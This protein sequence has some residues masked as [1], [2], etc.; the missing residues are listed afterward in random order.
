MSNC[1][2]FY[3]NDDNIGLLDPILLTT[4][5]E[6]NSINNNNNSSFHDNNVMNFAIVQPSLLKNIEISEAIISDNEINLKI[7][8][9]TFLV[10]DY[11]DDDDDYHEDD[12][13]VKSDISNTIQNY[14]KSD[15]DATFNIRMIDY[16][17]HNSDN[18]DND[19]CKNV[20]TIVSDNEIN[21]AV[22]QPH[23]F[24]DDGN[25]DNYD[26][27]DNIAGSY[28]DRPS[29]LSITLPDPNHQKYAKS[30]AAVTFDV[31]ITKK[32]N[33]TIVSEHNNDEY[34]NVEI[35][36]TAVSDIEINL[37]ITQPTFLDDNDNNDDNDDNKDDDDDI[38]AAIDIDRTS[39]SLISNSH[40]DI[41]RNDED[42]D[43]LN[44]AVTQHDVYEN[45]SDSNEENDEIKDYLD[46][47]DD[48][49]SKDSI[50]ISNIKIS[51][52]IVEDENAQTTLGL[53]NNDDYNQFNDDSNATPNIKSNS[54]SE[55]NSN[56]IESSEALR[57]NS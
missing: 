21:L 14:A 12:D 3:D 39:F 48:D 50:S 16:T 10:D 17:L 13:V 35:N 25:E 47:N 53:T 34:K 42:N 54:R 23:L 6:S 56:L 43:F 30:D 38:S 24:A 52:T 32:S 46:D 27:E 19:E 1:T 37:A 9:P 2:Q 5:I 51:Q 31:S 40:L 45:A 20:E 15:V 57:Y 29:S 28:N 41:E 4:Q 22:T 18:N 49:K 55:H 8:Q 7:T 26:N 44:L 11:N 33:E 36:E